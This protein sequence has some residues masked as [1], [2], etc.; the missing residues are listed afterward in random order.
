[1]AHKTLKQSPLVVACNSTL[2]D[3]F[4]HSADVATMFG[5]EKGA[6]SAATRDAL[7]AMRDGFAADTSGYLA[8]CVAIYGNG[9]RGKLVSDGGKRVAGSLRDALA[10]RGVSLD[11]VKWQLGEA[12]KVADYLADPEAK[13]TD[14]K[15]EPLPMRTL[16]KLALGDAPK[17]KRGANSNK[18]ETSAEASAAPTG[19][20]VSQTIARIG[21]VAVMAECA[22][23]LK[24][25][26]RTRTDGVAVAAIVEHIGAPNRVAN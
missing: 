16:Y 24:S 10:K 11:L 5:E 23:I 3:L 14:D 7:F 21:I 19:E 25:D 17:A 12:R 13:R 8:G 20:T 26:K 9:E 22:R 18:G 2:V 4:A 15:G 1:M 6:T